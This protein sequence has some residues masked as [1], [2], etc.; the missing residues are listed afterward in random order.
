MVPDSNFH[1]SVRD[2]EADLSGLRTYVVVAAVLVAAAVVAVAAV[3]VEGSNSFVS[4]Y[5]ALGEACYSHSCTGWRSA[6]YHDNSERIWDH[7]WDSHSAVPVD[8]PNFLGVLLRRV[9]VGTVSKGSW[10]GRRRSWRPPRSEADVRAGL[11]VV[12]G[13][14]AVAARLAALGYF[15]NCL[16]R[17][18]RLDR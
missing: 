1:P 12:A 2:A 14:V 5:W 4:N 18:G 7:N 8:P 10:R 3:V 16:S 15:R 9:G 17:R 13:P 6:S 11:V